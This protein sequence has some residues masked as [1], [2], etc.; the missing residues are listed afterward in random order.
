M[1]TPTRTAI[2]PTVALFLKLTA[3]IAIAL[4]LI[5]IASKLIMIA[6][7]AAIIAALAVGGILLYKM[8]RRRSNFPTLR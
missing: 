2:H 1:Q 7:V 4:V 6:F 5:W 8:I 3:A